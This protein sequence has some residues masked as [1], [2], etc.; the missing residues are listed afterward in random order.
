MISNRKTVIVAATV[1]ILALATRISAR[2]SEIV[3][4]PA[5][6]MTGGKPLME[7]LK[8]RQSS[9]DFE[10]DRLSLQVL[11]NLLWA[12]NGINRPDSGKR[13]APSAVNWQDIDIYLGTDG[14]LF[15]YLPKEHALKKILSEDVREAMGSQ[16]FV[17]SVPINLIYVSDYSRLARGTDEDKLFYSGAHSGFISQN[18]YLFCASEG[19]ATVVRGLVD[20][21]ALAKTMMLRPDQHITLGQSVGYPKN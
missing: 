3:K 14:G 8:S 10:L 7:C 6:Q 12:A 16:E 1:M 5:P 13:T 19:L 11:S 21:E 18:V 15:L 2:E 17:K 4:L 20:R 9:R